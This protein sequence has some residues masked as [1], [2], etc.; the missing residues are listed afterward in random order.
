[1]IYVF[2]SILLYQS[3]CGLVEGVKNVQPAQAGKWYVSQNAYHQWRNLQG[4]AMLSF[5]AACGRVGNSWI[6][7]AIVV[8]SWIAADAFYS[9]L[10]IRIAWGQW[11]FNWNKILPGKLP[12]W[13]IFDPSPAADWWIFGVAGVAVIILAVV[14]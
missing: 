6:L 3:A 14:K 9:R 10:L 13:G 8:L 11:N 12:W 7:A 2:L 4:A 1:M 5:G